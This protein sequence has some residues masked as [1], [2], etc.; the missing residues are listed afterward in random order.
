MKADDVRIKHQEQQS[1]EALLV[2]AE[3]ALLMAACE[4]FQTYQN[5]RRESKIASSRFRN[6]WKELTSKQQDKLRPE[7]WGD[8]AKYI[9]APRKRR[10]M[11]IAHFVDACKDRGFTPYLK[12]IQIRPNETVGFVHRYDQRRDHRVPGGV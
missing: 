10:D 3:T 2:E 11:R 1:A 6:T 7:L 12:G 8:V 5:A 9:D 4:E